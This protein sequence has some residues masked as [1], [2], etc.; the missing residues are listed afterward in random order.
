MHA[1]LFSI[2]LSMIA[3][4]IVVAAVGIVSASR[5]LAWLRAYPSSPSS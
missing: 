2:G 3:F 1:T 4:G 5:L